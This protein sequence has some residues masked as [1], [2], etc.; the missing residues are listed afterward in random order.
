[1]KAAVQTGA[2]T[3]P[4]EAKWRRPGSGVFCLALLGVTLAAL[5]HVAVTSKQLEIGLELGREQ[6]FH[7]ELLD[8][9]KHLELELG[10]LKHPERL[11]QIA[12][13]TLKMAPP[14]PLAIRG[15]EPPRPLPLP[16]VPKKKTGAH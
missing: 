16:P 15:L 4:E 14:E 12:R 13:D 1:V 3:A 5:G 9:K 8:R 2:K 10:R 11:T 7:G 6:R